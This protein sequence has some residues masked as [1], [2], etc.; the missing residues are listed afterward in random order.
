MSV[1]FNEEK[2]YTYL[3][4][5]AMA[6]NWHET[7]S[8]LAFARTAHA[9]QFRKSGEPYIVHPLTV[10]NH[11]IALGIRE[12]AIIAAAI[13][14]DVSEDCGTLPG[15]LPVSEDIRDAV[16]KLTHVNGEPI[17]SYYRGIR[18]NRIASIVKLLDRCN[19]VSTMAGV[20]STEKVYQYIEE[21]RQHVLPLLR[22]TKDHWV[23]DSDI[24]FVLKYHIVSVIDGLEACLKA[25]E[26]EKNV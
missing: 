24:L 15:H 20:F 10:A 6:M 21:T 1:H 19:N 16:W 25:K 26:E 17:E 13:L 3:K 12:D 18:E 22:W 2:M 7:L 4:G 9:G 5:Y 23:N 11:A 14:H 8:A